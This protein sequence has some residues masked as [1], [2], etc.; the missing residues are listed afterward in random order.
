VR[1]I[2]SPLPAT[3]LLLGELC[4]LPRRIKILGEELVVF[5]NRSGAVGLLELHCPH[6]GSSLE[7]GLVDAQGIRCCY[8]GWL[9]GVDG[10][11][12][13]TPGEPVESTL[14]DPLC[15]QAD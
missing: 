2:F 14:K 12:L 15:P 10:P 7:F 13:D 11:I 6:C 9:F 5:R 4:D 8:H 1:R 3:D